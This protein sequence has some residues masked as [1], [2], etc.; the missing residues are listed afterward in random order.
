MMRAVR[1][2]IAPDSF[3][4]TLT[5]PEAAQALAA[6]W[7]RHAPGD[8]LE[9]CPLSDGGPGF[10]DVLHGALGGR[11]IPVEVS[12]PRGEP[13]LAVVL[14]TQDGTAYLESAQAVGL[15]LVPAGRRDPGPA[16]SLGLGTLMA[17]ALDS[18]ATRLVIGLGG[19]A[20]NDGGAGMLA[21][22]AAAWQLPGADELTAVLGHGG[23]ALR[24][25]TAGR[26]GLLADVRERVSG[27]PIVAASDV[28][29]VLL[30]FKGASAIFGAQK[31]ASEEQAQALDLALSDFARAALDV[32]GQGQKL[33]AEPGAGAA[34]GLG[35]GLFLLG[36][37]RQPGA[38][39]VAGA[40]GLAD[41][42]RAAG[43]V[44]TGEGSLDWQSLRGKVVTA[45]AK[46]AL[47]VGVPTVAIAGQVLV[48]RRE[49][50]SVGV[51]SAYPVARTPAEVEQSL[52]DPAGRLAAR[53][54][55]VART[56]SP[57]P[58]SPQH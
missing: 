25:V 43:L 30:G 15:A 50:L 45:V 41:R 19:S 7:R 39:T 44:V 4:G 48:G 20:T 38:S 13:A 57:Q 8:E 14:L 47:E 23:E 6:G 34:G 18:G 46:L 54:E 22:L 40:L 3:A 37:T 32:T 51:E 11:L 5:A 24:G 52:A 12:G 55:R 56:W 17:A 26:L 1:V 29:V 2:L 58:P 36:A 28:D 35:F 42:I 27:V 49:L 21:G 33:V 16:T 53:A 9:L 31:G 10:V